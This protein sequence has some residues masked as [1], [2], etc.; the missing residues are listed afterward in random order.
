MDFKL[1]SGEWDY[2]QHAGAIAGVRV[3][4]GE[5]V[6]RLDRV[7]GGPSMWLIMLASL[8]LGAAIFVLFWVL[9]KAVVFLF[10]FIPPLAMALLRPFA[11]GP[12]IASDEVS[13]PL[14]QVRNVGG[15][16]ELVAFGLTPADGST[17]VAVLLRMADAMEAERLRVELR[18]G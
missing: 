9:F 16:G 18:R 17:E 7:T 3:V 15:G 8:L 2:P 14:S 11:G 13:F 4:S 10:F 1:L 6:I 12:R 5:L